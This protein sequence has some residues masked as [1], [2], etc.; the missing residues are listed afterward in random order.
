MAKTTKSRTPARETED[1]VDRYNKVVD[2]AELNGIQ[3]VHVNFDV[4]SRYFDNEGSPAIGY[5]VKTEDTYYD[6][7]DG[8][9]ACLVNFEVEA[10]DDSGVTLE[11]SA[12]YT[13]SYRLSEACDEKA[14]KIFLRRVGVFAC[15]PYFR[16]LFASLDWS[17]NTR[18]PPLPVHKENVATRPKKKVPKKVS[19]RET[20]VD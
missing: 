1:H 11:C 12:K 17:A 18:L 14:V 9:A 6:V 16:G 13:V 15:Y 10:K 7:E 4:M 8:F 5:V 20:K 2:A 19:A 3:L